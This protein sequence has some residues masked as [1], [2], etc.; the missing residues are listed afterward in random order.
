MLV[1]PRKPCFSMSTTEAPARAAAMAAQ[2]PAEP[3]PTTTTSARGQ[4]GRADVRHA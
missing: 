4:Q 3:A 1:P 2:A